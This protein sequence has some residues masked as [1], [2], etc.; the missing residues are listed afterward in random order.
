VIDWQRVAYTTIAGVLIATVGVLV[1]Q[2]SMKGHERI[3]FPSC[4]QVGAPEADFAPLNYTSPQAV[5]SPQASTADYHRCVELAGV[6]SSFA[7]HRD[8][9]ESEDFMLRAIGKD[10]WSRKTL[11]YVYS[12][13]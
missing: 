13:P 1:G 2:E 12:H 11:A 3:I 5:A 8:E 4:Q 6:T 7:R 9:G 10:G